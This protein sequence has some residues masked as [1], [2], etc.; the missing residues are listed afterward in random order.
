MKLPDSVRVLA[1][2]YHV[3]VIW[4]QQATDSMLCL[5]DSSVGGTVSP[6]CGT[7]MILVHIGVSALALNFKTLKKS[8]NCC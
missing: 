8:S 1:S 5:E 3:S 4:G 2:I 7:V 6:F